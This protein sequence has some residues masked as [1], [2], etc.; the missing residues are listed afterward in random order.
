[1]LR[2]QYRTWLISICNHQK[3]KQKVTTDLVKKELF[4]K[5]LNDFLS[6]EIDQ[7]ISGVSERNLCARLAMRIEANLAVLGLEGYYA[8]PEYNRKQEGRVKT[9][10]DDDNREIKICCDIVVHTRGARVVGDN[11]IAIEMKKTGVSAKDKSSDFDRLRAMTKQSFDGVWS[12]DGETHPEHVCGYD[13]GV[14][15]EINPETG[16][17]EVVY[18]RHGEIED[19]IA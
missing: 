12:A 16:D 13:L 19:A 14:Y 5:S 11:L 8:D 7:I 18:F 6:S 9:I 4:E 17:S 3:L 2:Q 10:L 1:M 15:I